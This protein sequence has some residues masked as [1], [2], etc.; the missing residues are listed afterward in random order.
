MALF[1]SFVAFVK[2]ELPKRVSTDDSPISWVLNKL[3]VATGVGLGTTAKSLVD[4]G[5]ASQDSLDDLETSLQ[6]Y[7]DSLVVKLWKDQGSYDISGGAYPTSANTIGAVPINVGFIWTISV[8]GVSPSSKAMNIGDTIR[9]IV[10][11]PTNSPAD[12]AEGEGNNGYVPENIDNKSNDTTLSSDSSS[13]YT[14]EHAVIG[15]VATA[16]TT[17]NEFLSSL[18]RIKDFTD[19]TK[20]K[21]W[22]LSNIS[23]ATTRTQTVADKDWNEGDL[24]NVATTNGNS[25]IGTTN[26][27][28]AGS[29]NT[30]AGNNQVILNANGID[31][32]TWDDAV[33][34]SASTGIAARQ[35]K[36]LNVHTCLA[37][38]TTFGIPT[39]AAN[40]SANAATYNAT[41]APKSYIGTVEVIAGRQTFNCLAVHEI[42]I[43][44]RTCNVAGSSVGATAYFMG[45][46]RVTVR[47]NGSVVVVT[48]INLDSDDVGGGTPVFTFTDDNGTL[49][50]EAKFN[51]ELD[52][53]FSQSSV[54]EFVVDSTYTL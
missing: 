48:P 38:I 40:T 1:D 8:P 16:L 51:E 37:L 29:N 17:L 23:T 7:A 32:V 35:R 36:V 5:I 49:K 28:I 45:K 12:W 2:A 26:R 11:N 18:F 39:A 10:D 6:A 3:V 15:Y 20:K 9:A 31:E 50:I 13:K 22:D 34:M 27:I 21:A 43:I 54:W 42:T 44:G 52:G 19:T 30:L 14:T 25:I 24:P 33:I 41:T 46:R 4:L 53:S 47:Y